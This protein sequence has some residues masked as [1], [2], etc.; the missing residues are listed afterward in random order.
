MIED[1]IIRL[2][3]KSVKKKDLRGIILDLRANP[4]GLL[5]E[6]INLSSLFLKEGLV[7]MIEGKNSKNREKRYVKKGP[8]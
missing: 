2:S 8:Y 7:V 1:A 6:A 4:G 3:K 5:E